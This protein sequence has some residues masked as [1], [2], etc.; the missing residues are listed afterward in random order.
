MSR[1]SNIKHHLSKLVM[2]PSSV[3]ILVKELQDAYLV[4]MEKHGYL[5]G[6][7]DYIPSDWSIKLE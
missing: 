1:P 3:Q 5:E 7:F 4:V 6:K 2:I